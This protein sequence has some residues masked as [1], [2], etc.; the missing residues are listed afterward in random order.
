M[1]YAPDIL[2]RSLS[3]PA[4]AG[5]KA[6]CVVNIQ[7]APE[8]V[9]VNVTPDKRSVMIQ[10]ES[11]LLELLR[12]GLEDVWDPAKWQAYKSISQKRYAPESGLLLLADYPHVLE[13]ASRDLPGC[14]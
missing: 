5:C 4:T 2:C 1:F 13:V 3:S 11:D 12:T 10:Q 14:Q 8:F 7:V 6:V 9:D